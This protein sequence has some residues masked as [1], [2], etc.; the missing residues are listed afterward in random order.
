M[1]FLFYFILKLLPASGPLKKPARTEAPGPR[2]SAPAAGEEGAK[3]SARQRVGHWPGH[4][5]PPGLQRDQLRLPRQH[6]H[7]HPPRG[8][9]LYLFK[10]QLSAKKNF[11]FPSATFLIFLPQKKIFF[12]L[13]EFGYKPFFLSNADKNPFFLD[14]SWREKL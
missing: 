2:P 6:G 11:F 9:V 13:Q 10:N 14:N 5:L 12:F 7:V 8:T 3:T 1:L 4:R